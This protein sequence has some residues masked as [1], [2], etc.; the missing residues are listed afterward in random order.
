MKPDPVFVALHPL[1]AA[2]A[3]GDRFVL[4]SNCFAA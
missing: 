1:G 4:F 2:P 3:T